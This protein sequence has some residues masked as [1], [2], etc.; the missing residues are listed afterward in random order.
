MQVFL[1]GETNTQIKEK[2]DSMVVF[3][4]YYERRRM[5]TRR[6]QEENECQ[7]VQQRS[8]RFSMI[9]D[10]MLCNYIPF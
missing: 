9:E 1:L 4:M 5:V 7:S 8:V 3:H 2:V 6:A 10:R